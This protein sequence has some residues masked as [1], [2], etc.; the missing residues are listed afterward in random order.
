MRKKQNRLIPSYVGRVG[1]YETGRDMHGFIIVADTDNNRGTIF[2]KEF[3]FVNCFGSYGSDAGQFV[4][5]YGVAISDNGNIY[6]SDRNN[7]RI[8]IFSY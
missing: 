4:L 7:K 1:M 5:P 3:K 6:V 2:D 8:Q